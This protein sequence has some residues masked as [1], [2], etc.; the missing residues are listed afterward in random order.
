MGLDILFLTFFPFELWLQIQIQIMAL[1][2]S[3]DFHWQLTLRLVSILYLIQD[4]LL[5]AG[6]E[7]VYLKML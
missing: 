1:L 4:S 6:I 2:V 3:L 7:L 5:D